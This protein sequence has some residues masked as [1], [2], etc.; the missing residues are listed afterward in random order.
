MESTISTGS[1]SRIGRRIGAAAAIALGA[2]MLAGPVAAQDADDEAA[3]LAVIDAL[4]D[5][6]RANDG[7]GVAAVFAEG[8][9]LIQ[10]EA[11][12]GSPQTRFIPAS[13]FAG[14]VGGADRPFDEPYWDPV[15][16]VHDHLASVWV[17]Y[18]FYLDGEF[19]HCGVDA[20]ILAR[21]TDGW[22]IAALAD[23]RERVNCELPPDRQ[24]Y[25]R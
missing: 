3:V 24:P 2:S 17:K 21:S 12:D 4:F 1:P 19:S 25:E 13:N 10:T 9:H 15:V 6:M 16:Q 11:G 14:A 7:E 18:A 20:F 22:K 8:A 23:T 5:A